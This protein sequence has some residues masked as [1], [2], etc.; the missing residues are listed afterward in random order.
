MILREEKGEKVGWKFPRVPSSLRNVWQG[1][2]GVLKPKFAGEE[3]PDNL[4]Q[5][6]VPDQITF[7]HWM[8]V[9]HGSTASMQM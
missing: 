9:V 3:S 5:D 6:L 8:Q 2:W 4:K 1:S 7:I